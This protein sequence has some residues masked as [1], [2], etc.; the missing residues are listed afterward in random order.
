ME[1]LNELNEKGRARLAQLRDELESLELYGREIGD[2]KY[3]AELESQRQQLA[4]Y[5]KIHIYILVHRIQ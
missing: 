1:T 3:A 5:E 4:W 2:P